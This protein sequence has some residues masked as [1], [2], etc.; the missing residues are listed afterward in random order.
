MK[1]LRLRE[2]DLLDKALLASELSP[3]I[4]EVREIQIE[5]IDGKI[6]VYRLM[7]KKEIAED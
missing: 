7:S 3:I 6:H 4:K 1:T 2:Q 5:G